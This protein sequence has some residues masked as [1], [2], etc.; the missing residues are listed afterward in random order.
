MKKTAIL[1]DAVFLFSAAFLPILCLMRYHR[2]TLASAFLSALLLGIAAAFFYLALARK[3]R[4]TLTLRKR[5]Q[6]E[7]EDVLFALA[8]LGKKPLADLFLSVYLKKDERA[9]LKRYGSSYAVAFDEF[10][11]FPVFSVCELSLTEVQHIFRIHTAK[12]KKIICNK[13]SDQARALCDKLS[14]SVLEDD[15]VYRLIK[16]SGVPVLFEGATSERTPKFKRVFKRAA[17]KKNAKRFLFSGGMLF[18][19]SLISP[20]PVYYLLF[21]GILTATALLLRLIGLKEI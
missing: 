14:L 6:E 20:Y 5:E 4:G 12:R 15:E 9:Q 3:K 10:V 16:E 18:A 17:L 11:C 19:L 8:M 1:S 21:G 7:K 2:F 13:L